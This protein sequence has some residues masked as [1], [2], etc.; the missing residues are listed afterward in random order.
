M[1]RT[2]WRIRAILAASVLILGLIT[3]ASLARRFA[4]TSNTKL[5]HFDAIV[6][7]GYRAD[8]DGDPTPEA[9][10]RVTEGVHEYERGIAPRLIITGGPVRNQFV[11]AEVMAR[12]AAAQGIPPSAIFIEPH[13]RDTIQNACYSERIMAAHGWRSAEVISSAYHL[14]R[15]GRIFNRLPLQWRTHAAPSLEPASTFDSAITEATETMSMIRYLTYAEWADR[16]E[17]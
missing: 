1:K 11:E 12:T 4:P 5:E 9:L 16:C 2:G 15:A 13:A 17:P 14:P 10:A 8:A 7:L 6:V 3:W